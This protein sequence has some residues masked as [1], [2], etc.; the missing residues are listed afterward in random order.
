[1]R[2]AGCTRLSQ[3]SACFRRTVIYSKQIYC[4]VGIS[5]FGGHPED[6]ASY[7]APLLEH[8]RT[9]IPPSLHSETPIF[10]YATAGMR[11][12][13][14]RQR[15]DV[16][17][18]TCSFLKFH[19]N[20][21]VEAASDVGRCGSSIRVITGEEEGL[22]G[23]IAVNYL[24]DQFTEHN[25]DRTTYGFLDMGGAS[26]QIA[27]EPSLGERRSTDKLTEVRLRLVGGEEIRHEVFVTTWLGYG[28]NQARERYIG[29]AIRHVEAAQGKDVDHIPDPCLPRNLTLSEDFLHSNHDRSQKQRVVVGTGSFEQCLKDVAPL[30]NK[31]A[32]CPDVPCLFNGVHVPKIDF[33][34]SHFIGVSEYWYSSEHVYGLGGAYNFA[35][36]ERAASR[37][38]SRSWDEIQRR[39]Q[40]SKENHALGGD[41]VLEE[42]GAVLGVGKWGDNVEIPRLQ[43]QC[44]KS[45]WLA[46]VLHEGIGMPRLVDP[47]GNPKGDASDVERMAGQKGLGKPLM[48]SLDFIGDTAIS[49][50][51]GKMVLVASNEVPPL[52]ISAPDILDP[53]PVVGNGS[54]H[55]SGGN[56]KVDTSPMEGIP[57]ATLSRSEWTLSSILFLFVS[58]LLTVALAYRLRRPLSK[59]ARRWLRQPFRKDGVDNGESLEDGGFGNGLVGTS[60]PWSAPST[61]ASLLQSMRSYFSRLTTSSA[62]ASTS[63]QPSPS[64]FPP[65]HMPST[66]PRASQL[67]SFSSP[68][69]KTQNGSSVKAMQN[70]SA[71]ASFG[72]SWTPQGSF[73]QSMAA[74][75]E[76]I[77][78]GQ[79]TPPYQLPRSR[80]NSQMNLTMLVPRQS[81]SRSASGQ[82]TPTGLFHD[83]D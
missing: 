76:G 42:D 61:R 27:F 18:A 66:Y 38:C 23:W 17:D 46:N 35:E 59:I 1:M 45:A 24:M 36:F 6:V 69:T 54:S 68:S 14:D 22:F 40:L 63:A 50:T 5:S 20:F 21:R 41:G 4:T 13:P 37:F 43:M 28:T 60:R 71:S 9:H 19:S 34:V 39:H 10:L 58:L 55:S 83:G 65:H 56:S 44:F 16:I 77:L 11:L 31:E 51:L 53:S 52:K 8:A 74:E 15:S 30:L 49:W 48:Q 75:G 82:H 79:G 64:L 32:P 57:F 3:V 33:S 26:T 7:L 67:R 25:E 62:S 2:T 78:K 70:A 80:N 72:G 12:L 81:V 73:L 47:G 29:Q